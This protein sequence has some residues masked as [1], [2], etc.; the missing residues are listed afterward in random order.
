MP[1]DI[2]APKKLKP[3]R[4]PPFLRCVPAVTGAVELG[5]ISCA[6]LENATD[7]SALAMTM[8]GERLVAGQ[9]SYSFTDGEIFDDGVGRHVRQLLFG[10]SK[11]RG[12]RD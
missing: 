3:S 4:R 11:I 6:S 5:E 1:R 8:N 7:A 9:T 10:S 12:Q 2:P